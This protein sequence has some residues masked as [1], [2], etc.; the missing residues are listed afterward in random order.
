MPE[1]RKFPHLSRHLPRF[2]S[3]LFGPFFS[4]EDG[5]SSVE[6]ILILAGVVSILMV[7][8][9]KFLIPMSGKLLHNMEMQINERFQKGDGLHRFNI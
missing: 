9:R 5:Q 8:T 6:Y 7:F 2:S 3:G 4:N 1:Q